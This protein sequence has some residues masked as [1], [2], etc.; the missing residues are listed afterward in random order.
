MPGKYFIRCRICKPEQNNIMLFMRFCVITDA[1]E[2]AEEIARAS[3]RWR[4]FLEAYRFHGKKVFYVNIGPFYY[5]KRTRIVN[6]VENTDGFVKNKEIG[7]HYFELVRVDRYTEKV[8][9]KDV[10]IPKSR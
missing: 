2:V 9:D 5:K 3:I 4:D 1:P 8:F 6:A 7:M 10:F